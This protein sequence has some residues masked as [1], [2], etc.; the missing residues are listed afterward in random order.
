MYADA[1]APLIAPETSDMASKTSTCLLASGKRDYTAV[2][3][4][5]LYE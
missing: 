3:W 5:T 4:V 1:E 2:V